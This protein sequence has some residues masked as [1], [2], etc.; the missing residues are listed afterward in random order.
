[1]HHWY[2]HFSND[3]SVQEAE[4]DPYTMQIISET[5]M[6][7]LREQA[8]RHRLATQARRQQPNQFRAAAGSWLISVGERLLPN[9]SARPLGLITGT[10][11]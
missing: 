1:M 11:R 2:N 3:A 10:D 7:E 6:K 4:M 8:A 5:R 9:P